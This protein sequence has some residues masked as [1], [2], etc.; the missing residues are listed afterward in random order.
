M[1]EDNHHQLEDIVDNVQAEDGQGDNNQQIV[2]DHNNH[3]Q[4]EEDND[5]ADEN[6]SAGSLHS[7]DGSKPKGPNTHPLGP[8]NGPLYSTGTDY[9]QYLSSLDK[10]SLEY[11]LYSFIQLMSNVPK[12][13]WKTK[14]EVLKRLLQTSK[15]ENKKIGSLQDYSGEVFLGKPHG[16][17]KHKYNYKCLYEGEYCGGEIHGRGEVKTIKDNKLMRII[18]TDLGTLQGHAPEYTEDWWISQPNTD[19]SYN[20]GRFDGPYKH[21][22]SDGR[23]KFGVWRM[24]IEEGPAMLVTADKTMMKFATFKDDRNHSEVRFYKL[25]KIELYINGLQVN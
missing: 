11:I 21:T 2:D 25:D 17:G 18:N 10:H 22:F 5:S 1:E 14:D 3:G 20:K 13:Y 19:Y 8:Y 4:N 16:Q 9:I 15:V 7:D 23:I 6:G 12:E 24:G